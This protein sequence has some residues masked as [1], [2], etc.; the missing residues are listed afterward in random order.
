MTMEMERS[1]PSPP[2]GRLGVAVW[3]RRTEAALA[4]VQHTVV[5]RV[6]GV[7]AEALVQLEKLREIDAL[8]REA[9]TGQAFIRRWTDAL[10]NGDPF[11][12]DD[13]KLFGDTAKLGK[14]EVLADT[15]GSFCRESGR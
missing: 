8:A 4:R 11:L 7:Q 10:A 14:A 6:A 5:V 1:Q 9:A 15:I 2:P 3:S 12:A 13:L